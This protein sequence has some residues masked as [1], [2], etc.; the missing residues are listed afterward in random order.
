MPKNKY[1]LHK[2]LFTPLLYLFILLANGEWIIKLY[3]QKTM[4][5]VV[6]LIERLHFILELVFILL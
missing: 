2:N 5:P 4:I 6:A 3:Q 1:D